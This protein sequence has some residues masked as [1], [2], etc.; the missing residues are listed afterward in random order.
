MNPSIK[1]I[2]L[3]WNGNEILKACLNSIMKIDYDNYSTVVIDNASIDDSCNMVDKNFPK[4]KLFKLDANYGYAKG[5]NK[6]F[7]TNDFI[8]SNYILLLNNDTEVAPNILSSFIRAISVYGSN[9]IFGPKI[10]YKNQPD[11]LWYAGGKIKLRYGKISH[12]GIRN[13][14]G[15]QYSYPIKTDYITGCCLFTSS[16]VIDKLKGFDEKFN[17]YGEDVDLC[18]RAKREGIQSYYWP[19]TKIYHHVSASI[20][21]NWNPKKNKMKFISIIR[22]WFKHYLNKSRKIDE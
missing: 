5:Y 14:D 17:M 22:L 11:K 12:R 3:N 21:G 9:N 19:D 4:V 7:K 2:I 18:I 8:D 1:I 16:N 6:Y 15:L 13:K 20:G 10:F